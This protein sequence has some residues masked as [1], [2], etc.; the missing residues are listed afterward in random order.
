MIRWFAQLRRKLLRAV[1]D[2]HPSQNGETP[3]HREAGI[4]GDTLSN[5]SEWR[6]ESGTMWPELP[7]L[8]DSACYRFVH[9]ERLFARHVSWIWP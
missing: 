2:R 6:R 7:R 9:L 1:A 8:T 4:S 3:I 5:F